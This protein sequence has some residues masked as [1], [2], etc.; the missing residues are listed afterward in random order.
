[1]ML[2]TVSLNKRDGLIGWLD[3]RGTLPLL[4]HLYQKLLGRHGLVNCVLPESLQLLQVKVAMEPNDISSTLFD[5]DRHA[6]ATPSGV[7]GHRFG[8]ALALPPSQQHSVAK[9]VPKSPLA[10]CQPRLNF[11]I[12]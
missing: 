1:M 6:L 11:H 8:G 3:C 10:S 2:S 9:P 4:P 5:V 7:N 12:L